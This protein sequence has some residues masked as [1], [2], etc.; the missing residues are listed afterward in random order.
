[1][2]VA[3]LRPLHRPL[4]CACTPHAPHSPIHTSLCTPVPSHLRS[5][6]PPRTFVAVGSAAVEMVHGAGSIGSRGAAANKHQRHDDCSG[7]QLR[8]APISG[9]K[10]RH[11]HH[12]QL[13]VPNALTMPH[14][15]GGGHKH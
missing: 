15:G 9:G 12:Q 11:T 5:A 8:A 10:S 1:M 14:Q 7:R 3:P 4:R 2:S 13:Y 6:A